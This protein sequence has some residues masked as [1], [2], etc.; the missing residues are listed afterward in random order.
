MARTIVGILQLLLKQ[1]VTQKAPEV[2][3]ALRGIQ[4]AANRLGNA[5]WGAAFDRQLDKLRI[6]SSERAAITQS[7]GLLARDINGKLARADLATWKGGVVS[8]L[9]GVRAQMVATSD[10]A[11]ATAQIIKTAFGSGLLGG[12]A[13]YGAYA[14]MRGGTTAAFEQQRAEAQAYFAG[15]PDEDRARIK[16]ASEELSAKWGVFSADMFTVLKE[17]SL[18]MPSTDLALGAGETMAKLFVVLESMFGR[19]GAISGLYSLNK[20]LDNVELNLTPEMYENAI[21]QYLKAQQVL[22][23]D[24][25]PESFAQALKYARIAGKAL[26]EDFLFTWLPIIAAET[27]GADAGGQLRANF[28][29]LVGGRAPEKAKK[30]MRAWGVMDDEGNLAQQGAYDQNPVMWAHDVLL[31]LLQEAGVDTENEV[32]LARALAQ[33]TNNRL[34]A[35][36]LARSILSFEQYLRTA[37]E[38]IPAAKGLSAAEDVRAMDPFAAVTGM[39]NSLKNLAAAIGEDA[40]P[41]IIPFMTSF[42]QGVETVAAA[43]RGAEG[44]QVGVGAI[45]A[46]AGALG[47]L[48]IGAAALGGI[49]A[50]TTAGPSLQTAAVMLQGAAQALGGKG[51][52]GAVGGPAGTA[53]G[54]GRGGATFMLGAPFI[55]DWIGTQIWDAIH[56]EGATALGKEV[57]DG[58]WGRTW[59]RIFGPGT[60]G[61]NGMVGEEAAG[62]LTATE[63]AAA[64]AQAQ[65]DALMGQLNGVNSTVA[66]QVDTSSL[67]AA[68][69]MVRQLST[70][71]TALAGP[72]A[73]K[74]GSVRSAVNSLYAD[75]G[76][77]P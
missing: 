16:K 67:V 10:Q 54:G 39:V 8:H 73:T 72:I 40:V 11:K 31:P 7:Y 68:L 42:A 4:D 52:S 22:G 63:A 17:A 57:S 5:P 3:R 69:S 47:A 27:S 41:V 25:S 15:L 9:V 26:S 38:R 48:K 43:V 36:M 29:Q 70:A 62:T 59:E 66:P 45:A 32:A 30:Q 77:A 60:P 37:T 75:Y 61:S 19:E 18:S 28:D 74:P 46:A 65:V 6:T 13:T 44:W 23:K 14:G 33:M 24:L 12:L 51:L 58:A 64:N 1:D 56:G 49:G 34:S 50:L 53:A 20:A 35:D 55:A 76:I 2:N 21:N 71:L